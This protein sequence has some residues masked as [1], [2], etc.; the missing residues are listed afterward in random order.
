[1][2]P[3]NEDS[4]GQSDHTDLPDADV[5]PIPAYV[6]RQYRDRELM[7]M[8]RASFRLKSAGSEIRRQTV[9]RS[10]RVARC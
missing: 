4:Y 8:R 9:S 7:T 3:I 2:V 6:G 1:M 5:R 10:E